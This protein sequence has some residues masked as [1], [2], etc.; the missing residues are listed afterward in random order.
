[1]PRTLVIGRSPFADVVVAETTVAAHHLELVIADDGRLHVTDCATASGT[2][3]H[4]PAGDGS[5][6]EWTRLRQA[7]VT[8]ETQL[9]LGDYR[10]TVADLLT[11]AR[12]RPLAFEAGNALAEGSRP[13][14]RPAEPPRGRV[15]RDAA[16][17]EI[18]RRRP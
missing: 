17:G 18:V 2:W 7:F 16:T 3:C 13:A 5:A 6:G 12:Y 4:R 15:E 1:M 11:R 9:G 10:C 14:G 8:P